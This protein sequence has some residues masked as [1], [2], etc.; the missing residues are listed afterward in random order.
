MLRLKVK[1]VKGKGSPT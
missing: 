1:E